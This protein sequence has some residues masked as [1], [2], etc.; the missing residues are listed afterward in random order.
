M[1]FPHGSV[2]R[3]LLGREWRERYQGSLLG[4]AW[5]VLLPLAQ[6]AVLAFVFGQLLPARSASAGM[7]YPV[8]LALGLFPWLLFANAVNRGVTTYL[9]HAGLIARVPLPP[10]LYV[11]A[12]V[13]AS[14]L[15]DLAGFLVVL[16]VLLV[17]GLRP[18]VPGLLAATAALAVLA[19]M[20]L[21]LARI[22]ALLQVFVRDLAP[23]VGQLTGLGFF[24]SPVLYERAQLPA[25]VAAA[26]GWNPLVAPIEAIRGGLSGSAALPWAALAASAAVAVLLLG[27]SLA[28]QRRAGRH[29]EDFL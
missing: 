7:A 21:A 6:L 16:A 17:F 18:P 5:L 23:L 29:L 20:A 10:A 26:L 25:P 19:L 28:L 15:V 11:H 9:D 12:R 27:L 4:A 1:R 3:E 13:L 14:V 24:L 8:F 22:A 2:L